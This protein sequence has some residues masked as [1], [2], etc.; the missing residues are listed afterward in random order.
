[1]VQR[2]QR[3]SR[4]IGYICLTSTS[5]SHSNKNEPK[6]AEKPQEKDK[7]QEKEKPQVAA[8]SARQPLPGEPANRVSPYRTPKD[9][10]DAKEKEGG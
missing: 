5:F 10:K 9:A 3:P 8:P 6:K 7:A 1:M 4:R 2:G